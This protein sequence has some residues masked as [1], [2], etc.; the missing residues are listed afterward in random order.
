VSKAE[1]AQSGQ[2]EALEQARKMADRLVATVNA[3][4]PTKAQLAELRQA[5]EDAP[6]LV[7]DLGDISRQLK[8]KIVHSLAPQPGLH[9]AVKKQAEQIA[10]EL[11]IEQASPLERLLIDQV[12]IAWLRWQ[13]VEWTYQNN[14]EQSITLTKG[15]YLEKRLTAAHR[16]YLQAIESLARVR[17]LLARAPVQINIA[18]QQIVQNG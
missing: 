13:A 15:I 11:G 10:K 17:R 4:K 6:E 7:S 2:A 16:R 8:Y 14:F 5:L 9:I 12:V 3:Q 18:Q 1:I